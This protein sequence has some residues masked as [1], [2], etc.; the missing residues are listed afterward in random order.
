MILNV[1]IPNNCLKIHETKTGTTERRDRTSVIWIGD[2]NTCL[3]A[4]DRTTSQ[5]SARI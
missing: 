4:N 2:F 1:Y 3:S 5:K